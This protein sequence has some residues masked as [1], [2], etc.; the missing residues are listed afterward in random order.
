[1]KLLPAL[2]RAREE[3]VPAYMN[4][5]QRRWGTARPTRGVE[6]DW[7]PPVYWNSQACEPDFV[8]MER[9]HCVCFMEDAP[10]LNYYKMLRVQIMQSA[11]ARGWKTIMIT[12]AL[13]GE[14]KTVTSINLAMTFAK[15]YNQTVLLMDCDLR[16]QKAYRYMGIASDLGII[17]HLVDGRPL[18]EI[19]IWPRI[20]KMTMI[21]GG[22]TVNESA[23]VLGSPKMRALVQEM[24]MRY[25]DRYIL[26][27]SAPVLSGADALT[28]TS[29]ADGIVMVVEAG[30]TPLRE[31]RE[32]LE[33]MPEEK[34][35]G[36]V[37]N[38]HRGE[39]KGYYPYY[40][41]PEK[42]KQ[43]R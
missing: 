18:N 43:R 39:K 1:M 42:G 12:S 27:D 34:F 28:L 17:D 9:N 38:K 41:Y 24:K 20:E 21:S 29:L 23:E 5:L 7:V 2:K 40:G 14:G 13:P 25:T 32:A 3:K 33:L 19:I 4:S 35:L 22:R 11:E 36:F 10:E 6:G 31:I 30:R 15:A 37:L 26:L 16:Q 8:A